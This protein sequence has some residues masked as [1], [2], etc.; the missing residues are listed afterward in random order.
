MD[1]IF[2]SAGD[3]D[4]SLFMQIRISLHLLF[5]RECA[6]K[7]KNFESLRELMRT[8]FFP[9]SPELGEMIMAKLSEGEGE[10]MAEFSGEVSDVPGGVSTL[11][12]VITGFFI[13]VSLVTSFFGSG[14][15]KIADAEGSSF[16]LPLGITI[17]VVLTV[18][19]VLFIG[20]HLKE[21][22]TR[23]RLH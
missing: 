13:L 5:C 1:K 23:F 12:W 14:F 2:E 9:P 4:L 20:S 17:G 16:L 7:A 21:L 22:S 10:D 8:G 3:E 6:E 11:G 15:A 18:Y 19:G